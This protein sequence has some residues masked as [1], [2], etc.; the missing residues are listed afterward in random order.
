MNRRDLFKVITATVAVAQLRSTPSTLVKYGH[1]TVRSAEA[2]G[3]I[4]ARV[5][6]NGVELDE[7][8][9]LNDIEGWVVVNVLDKSGHAFVVADDQVARTKLY[10]DITFQPNVG[11]LKQGRPS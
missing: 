10:G 2:N 11:E 6:L 4:P 7:V 8:V 3:W 9:E 5:L 1:V